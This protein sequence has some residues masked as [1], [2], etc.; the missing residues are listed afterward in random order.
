MEIWYRSFLGYPFRKYQVICHLCKLEQVFVLKLLSPMR[1]CIIVARSFSRFW[2]A[3]LKA[4]TVGL[5]A[6]A[7]IGKFYS[8]GSS[9][10]LLDFSLWMVFCFIYDSRFIFR[11][12]FLVNFSKYVIGSM[13]MGLYADFSPEPNIWQKIELY[14]PTSVKAVEVISL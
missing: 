5:G 12:F 7:S 6:T 2:Y 8:P 14:T 1:G 13:G 10:L 11:I 3:M 9:E 4:L